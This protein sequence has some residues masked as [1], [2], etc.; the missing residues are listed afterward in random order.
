MGV[1]PST[2]SQLHLS[3]HLKC[4]PLQT[5]LEAHANAYVLGNKCGDVNLA[6]LKVPLLV[7]SK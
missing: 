2:L 4:L 5:L 1:L 6:I 3:W 7:F